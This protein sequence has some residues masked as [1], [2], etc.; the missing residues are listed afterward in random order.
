MNLVKLMN[1]TQYFAFYPYQIRN[2]VKVVEMFYI[3]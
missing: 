3:L 1:A 2:V